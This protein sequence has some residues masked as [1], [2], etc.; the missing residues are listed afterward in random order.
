MMTAASTEVMSHAPAGASCE[1]TLADRRATIST[2]A[3]LGEIKFSQL[4]KNTL[5]LLTVHHKW[6][7]IESKYSHAGRAEEFKRYL[8]SSTA[9]KRREAKR[10]LSHLL[11]VA[12]PEDLS[13]KV[14]RIDAPHAAEL[15]ARSQEAADNIY[16]LQTRWH[17]SPANRVAILNKALLDLVVGNPEME[18]YALREGETIFKEYSPSRLFPED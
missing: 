14:A 7:G 17:A 1:N 11:G 8:Q 15:L 18:K 6:S 5:D 2:F 16:D 13:F 3:H 10:R 12:V 9:A 4:P